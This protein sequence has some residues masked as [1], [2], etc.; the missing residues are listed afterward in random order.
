MPVPKTLK[1]D[2]Y[3][4]KNRIRSERQYKKEQRASWL[5]SISK[6]PPRMQKDEEEFGN[7]IPPT[8]EEVRRS[9]KQPLGD[10]VTDEHT[11]VPQAPRTVPDFRA[12][13]EV[14]FAS[15]ARPLR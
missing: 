3:S 10:A 12:K 5:R 11:F 8:V 14:S 7:K 2:N 1:E 4:E 13:H 6:L 15:V 9:R